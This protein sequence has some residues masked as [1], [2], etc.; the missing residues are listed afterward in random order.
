[1]LARFYLPTSGEILLDGCNSQDHDLG[2]YREQLGFVPQNITLF[3]D[4]VAANIALGS[5]AGRSHEEIIVATERAQASKFVDDLERGYDTL[6]GDQGLGLSGGQQQRIAIAR[7]LL[8]Q[9]PVL[10]LDEATS[11]LDTESEA[12]IQSA[13]EAS[14]AGRTTFIVAHRLSTIE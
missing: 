3:S 4:S 9:A 13:L 12:L 6:I 5:M 2:H 1:L 8:K 11:A 14:R 7:A 10:I